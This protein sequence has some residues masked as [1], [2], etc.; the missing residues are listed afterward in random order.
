[1]G[2]DAFGLPAENAALERNI[3]ADTWTQNNIENM[4]KQ[5]EILGCSF[6]WNTELTTC[7]P[8]YYKWTQ[9]LFLRLYKE[10]LVY[11]KE[12]MVNWDPIDQTVLADEQVDENGCSWRSGAKVEKKLLK[13]W[14]IRTTKFA[15]ALVDGLDDATLVDWRDIINLQK[16]WLGDCNGFTFDLTIKTESNKPGLKFLTIWTENPEY[17]KTAAF[18]AVP[19]RHILNKENPIERGILRCSVINPFNENKKLPILVTD[20]IELTSV[21]ETY[22]GVPAVNETDLLLAQ[23]FNIPIN[24]ESNETDLRGQIISKAKKLNIGGY[25]VSSKLKDWLISRQRHWGT[26]I[27]IVHCPSCG[28]VPVGEKDLPVLLPTVKHSNTQSDKSVCPKCGNANAQRESDTMDTFVDSSWYFLRFIDSN[29]H[30]E[31]FDKSLISKCMPVDLYIGGKEHAVLHLY[32]ARFINHFLHSIG[33]VEQPEPFQRLLVQGM[34]MGRSYRV[35]GTGKYLKESEVKI[36]NAKKNQA[37]EITTNKQV[38]MQWEKMSK[39]KYNGVDPNEVIAEHGTDTVRLII[40]GDV[41]P[42]SHRNWSSASMLLI[43]FIIF[44]QIKFCSLFFSIPWHFKLAKAT[45]VCCK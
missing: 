6:D 14:F 11:Q 44:F 22:L 8:D 3:A 42:T 9:W 35:K 31:I 37:E 7:Q 26:P 18:I 25:L 30:N 12:A 28:P 20:D 33:L 15:K 24:S 10:G 19:K 23:E 45:M 40:L 38:V 27:P 41:A 1:M 39:S 4:K 29:N 2:W 21:H 32:Y 36:T 5:F 16:H 13:Q 17:L 43:Y 34:V